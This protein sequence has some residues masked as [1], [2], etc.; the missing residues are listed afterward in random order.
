MSFAGV[1]ISNSDSVVTTTANWLDQLNSYPQW[2]FSFDAD[3]VAP[4]LDVIDIS[5]NAGVDLNMNL[6][7]IPEEPVLGE[8]NLRDFPNEPQ[9]DA[10]PP[11]LSD[12]DFPNPFADTVPQPGELFDIVYP[13]EPEF[14]FPAVPTLVE[15]ALPSPPSLGNPELDEFLAEKP[16]APDVDVAWS[17]A[18]YESALLTEANNR[19]L[20]LITGALSNYSPQIEALIWQKAYD[21]EKELLADSVKNTI[22]DAAARGFFAPSGT[23]VSMLEDAKMEVTN[24][25]VES[26]RQLM[27]DQF[28]L[29]QKNFQMAL[30]VALNLESDLITK[31]TRMMDRSLDFAKFLVQAKLKLFEASVSLYLADAKIFAAKADAFRARIEAKVAE[32][33]IQR[34]QLEVLKLRGEINEQRVRIYLAQLSQLNAMVSIYRSRVDVAR[35]KVAKDVSNMNLYAA[36][37]KGIESQVKAKNAEVE[38]YVERLKA[39]TAKVDMYA[40][41]ADAFKSRADGFSTLIKAKLKILENEF[42]QKQSMPLEVYKQ[43][44]DAFRE[45]ANAQFSK[46]K[47]LSDVLAARIKAFVAEESAESDVIRSS[48]QLASSAIAAQGAGASLGVAMEDA[49]L[50]SGLAGDMVASA[51]AIAAAQEAAMRAAARISASTKNVSKNTSKSRSSSRNESTSNSK[52]L[53]CAFRY[54][55]SSY[56]EA[57]HISIIEGAIG[58][59]TEG[60]PGPRGGCG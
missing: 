37:I 40:T 1:A 35:L 36:K 59:F 12:I 57:S 16:I 28:E 9:F 41:Q 17:E 44:V 14:S 23:L 45:I 11:L 26:S 51:S 32:L 7:A 22:D 47:A 38:G 10:A 3:I 19:L 33:E 6:P 50:R 34:Q 20:A 4:I 30:S 43:K 21:L 42:K 52:S 53:V 29:Q 60:F 5:P 13:D 56:M 55:D 18:D 49:A 58:V 48:A 8:I 27:R 46:I 31:H 24:K 39:E 25:L 2:S 54:D 15:M